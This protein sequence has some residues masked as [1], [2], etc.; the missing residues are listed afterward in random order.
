MP[1]LQ[2]KDSFAE[3]FTDLHVGRWHF[4]MTAIGLP[5]NW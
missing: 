5:T 3:V 1:L 2:K 4:G